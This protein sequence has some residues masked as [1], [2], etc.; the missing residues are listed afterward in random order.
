MNALRAVAF[1]AFGLLLLALVVPISGQSGIIV[2]NADSVRTIDTISSSS[3]NNLLGGVQA[4]IVAQYANNLRD[5]PLSNLPA[6]LLTLLSGAAQRIVAQYANS[7]RHE[8]LV[9]A[10]NPF[11]DQTKIEFILPEFSKKVTLRTFD[12]TGR[13]IEQTEINPTEK[14]IFVGKNWENGVYFVQLD[15]DGAKSAPVKIVRI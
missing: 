1:I 11:T 8:A 10:P 14:S 12:L 15:I 5:L 6:P 3:L 2:N 13:Q 7:A 9:V 4:R